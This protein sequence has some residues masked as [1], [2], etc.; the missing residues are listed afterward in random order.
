MHTIII[1][2]GE[3]YISKTKEKSNNKSYSIKLFNFAP[4]ISLV[5]GSPQLSLIAAAFLV[6]SFGMAYF[7]SPEDRMQREF[8]HYIKS[9]INA[10]NSKWE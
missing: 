5:I 4:F 2:P 9:E 1:N 3:S 8:K 7:E 10:H 6:A